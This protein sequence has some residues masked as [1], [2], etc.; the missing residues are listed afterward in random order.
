MEIST[1]EGDEMMEIYIIFNYSLSGAQQNFRI[2][3]IFN[4]FNLIVILLLVFVRGAIEICEFCEQNG[5]IHKT[6]TFFRKYASVNIQTCSSVSTHSKLLQQ[7]YIFFPEKSW[8]SQ[9][10]LLA[11]NKKKTWQRQE[12]FF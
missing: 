12:K 4:Q 7:I 5:N 10:K 2:V 11:V 3:Y 9:V 6:E 1:Q 8:E